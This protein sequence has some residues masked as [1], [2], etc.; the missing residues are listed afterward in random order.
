MLLPAPLITP[1]SSLIPTPRPI[2]S[3]VS[4]RHANP[5]RCRS[6]VAEDS[7][8]P[9]SLDIATAAGLTKGCWGAKG[10]TVKTNSD[11]AEAQG[12]LPRLA[13][14]KKTVTICRGGKAIAFLL[15]RD[16]IESIFETLEIL[17]NPEAMK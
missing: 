1:N 11:I 17:S 2:A 14:S 13:R 4:P 16:R 7:G 6:P 15:P 9:E 8:E 3:T 12:E 5:D 10:L